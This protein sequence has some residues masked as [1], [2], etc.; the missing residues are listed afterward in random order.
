MNMINYDEYIWGDK[1]KN[2][3]S[4]NFVKIDDA[5][6]FLNR[7][8]KINKIVTHNGDLPVDASYLSLKDKFN[9]WFG[10][11]I[12]IDDEKIIPIPIGLEN[13]YV[14]NSIQK[15]HMLHDYSNKNIIIKKLLYINHNIG[16]NHAERIIPYNLFQTN[17]F[18]TIHS[19]DG[20]G[21]QNS[22]YTNIKEHEFILSPPGNGLD[23]HRTWEI[24][25]LG[26]IPILKNI[27]SLKKLYSNLPVIFIDKYE[28]IT[29]DFLLN[30]K[31]ELKNKS[32]NYNKLK[33]SYWK[34]LIEQE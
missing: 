27:G 24:L 3:S 8:S 13:D 12:I 15:K 20:F 21:G 23:C 30:K 17:N 9:F 26:R 22:Y 16:T 28:E 1:F 34:N 10:Q 31:N 29:E 4:C 18:I 7:T 25:Y 11:N 2:L 14:P 5:R 19:C 6:S 33:F 32:F